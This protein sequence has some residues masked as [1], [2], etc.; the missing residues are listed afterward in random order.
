M[1]KA[2]RLRKTFKLIRCRAN[3]KLVYII[4]Q[5]NAEADIRIIN[6]K[7]FDGKVMD[8]QQNRRVKASIKEL[9][10]ISFS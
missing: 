1:I 8:Y 6:E 5:I 7:T 2:V 10:F 4:N 3:A 9:A